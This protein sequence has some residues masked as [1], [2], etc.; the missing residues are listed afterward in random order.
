MKLHLHQRPH[1]SPSFLIKARTIIVIEENGLAGIATQDGVIQG[2]RIM[3]ARLTSHGM[4]LQ[5][6]SKY[7]KPDPKF[8][9]TPVLQ[10]IKQNSFYTVLRGCINID[11]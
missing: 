7:C 4:I 2:S 8:F 5:H 3:N 10:I 1:L 11:G 6:K 9:M